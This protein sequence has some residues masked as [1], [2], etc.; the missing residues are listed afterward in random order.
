VGDLQIDER[1]LAHHGLLVRHLLMPN[2]LESTAAILRF[3][4]EEISKNTYLNL[5]DQYRPAYQARYYP[6]IDRPI[7]RE[8]YQS[9]VNIALELGLLRLD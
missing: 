6:R 7:K 5:M 2:I 1:G 9:A 4:A 8:E 3:L